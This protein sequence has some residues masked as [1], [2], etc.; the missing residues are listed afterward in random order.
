MPTQVLWR[1]PVVVCVFVHRYPSPSRDERS[2]VQVLVRGVDGDHPKTFRLI[3]AL[4]E[5]IGAAD[6]YVLGEHIELVDVESLT[7][8]IDGRTFNWIRV[9]DIRPR[10]LDE[11]C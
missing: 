2:N 6:P 10:Y 11:G 7:T 3:T 9:R 8:E 5:T 1:R 4:V